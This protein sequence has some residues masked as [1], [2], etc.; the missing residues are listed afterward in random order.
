M[1]GGSYNYLYCHS[2]ELTSHRGDLQDMA[3]RLE[4]LPWAAQAAT[5]TRRLMVMLDDVAALAR[6][7]EGSWHAV[8]WWDSGDWGEESTR[9]EVEAYQLPSGDQAEDVLYRLVDVGS[10]AYE[11]RPVAATT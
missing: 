5:A 1:S 9:R 8:E 3:V 6:S 7:L 2:D 11:L 4:G 10:G